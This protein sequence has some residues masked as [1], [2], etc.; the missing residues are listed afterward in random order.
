MLSIV[1]GSTQ[2]QILGKVN[3]TILLYRLSVFQIALVKGHQQSKN[4]IFNFHGKGEICISFFSLTGI[5]Y[6]ALECSSISEGFADGACAQG[7]GKCCVIRLVLFYY[8]WI[9]CEMWLRETALFSI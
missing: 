3:Y 1:L 6:S 9:I 5:C 2:Y 8:H 4:I 7:F